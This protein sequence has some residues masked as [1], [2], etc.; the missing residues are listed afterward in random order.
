LDKEERE[1]HASRES[2]AQRHEQ[3]IQYQPSQRR[4]RRRSPYPR[5]WMAPVAHSKKTKRAPPGLE[6]L[7]VLD[8]VS[9]RQQFQPIY[10]GFMTPHVYEVRNRHG[11]LVYI[12]REE[13]NYG[14]TDYG[15]SL[16]P[17]IRALDM[18]F[19]DFS[20]EVVMDVYRPFTFTCGPLFPCLLAKIKV[21]DSEENCIGLMNQSSSFSTTRFEIV[22]RVSDTSFQ[23]EGPLL[24][25]SLGTDVDFMVKNDEGEVKGTIT[26][27]WKGAMSD[28]M[29]TDNYIIRFTSHM[30]VTTKATLVGAAII[31]DYMF[32]DD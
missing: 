5:G 27:R 17:R 1:V 20:N 19:R 21:Y 8:G 31:I 22:D 13:S 28:F 14:Y 16:D 6:N 26:K 4:L 23:L 3:V 12:A 25:D 30:T 9:I 10:A 18:I 7:A 11:E 32:Y 15:G 29:N 24:T 2:R